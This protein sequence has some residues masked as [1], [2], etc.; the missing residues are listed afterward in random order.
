[1]RLHWE[2]QKHRTALLEHWAEIRELYVIQ[3][4]NS[5]KN[6]T[7]DC[8][9]GFT[10]LENRMFPSPILIKRINST[11]GVCGHYTA[12]MGDPISIV[13]AGA[14][15]IK[16]RQVKDLANLNPSSYEAIVEWVPHAGM[17]RVNSLYKKSI[18]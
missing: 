4:C 13:D 15:I 14:R 12:L 16:N 9:L 10:D 7:R 17:D 2:V 6:N 5:Y 3:V 11:C 18:K 1:M 8:N